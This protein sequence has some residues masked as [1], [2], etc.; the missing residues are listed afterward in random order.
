MA[1]P[2]QSEGTWSLTDQMSAQ[3]VGAADWW[4]SG[5]DKSGGSRP[6]LLR[7]PALT[8]PPPP[9]LP[10]SCTTDLASPPLTALPPSCSIDLTSS[11]SLPAAATPL[12]A[13]VPGVEAQLSAAN[14]AH[15]AAT[16]CP[17]L[18][19][20]GGGGH[21]VRRFGVT[22]STLSCRAPLL[23]P[24]FAKPLPYPCTPPYPFLTLLFDFFSV[25]YLCQATHL[26][27]TCHTLPLPLHA[28][29]PFPYPANSLLYFLFPSSATLHLPSACH[30]LP[31]PLYASLPFPYPAHSLL[32]YL[33]PNSTMLQPPCPPTPAC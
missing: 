24:L 31:L 27:P 33:L 28:F 16:S 4:L 32:Y 20:G 18:R 17:L 8:P 25:F 2:G 12:E 26:P 11:P 1:S 23:L 29:L 13:E 15:P 7:S 6:P 30:T 21:L 22:V 10:P 3:G 5:A 19:L 9:A 14:A